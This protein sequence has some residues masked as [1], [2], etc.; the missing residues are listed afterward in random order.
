MTID[1]DKRQEHPKNAI[2][3]AKPRPVPPR[4]ELRPKP[5]SASAAKPGG[6]DPPR[7]PIPKQRPAP[8]LRPPVLKPV[9]ARPRPTP[10][11]APSKRV[12]EIAIVGI[13]G[14]YAKSPDVA[15]LW[16]NLVGG[17]NCVT[18]MPKERE[19]HLKPRCGDWGR[20]Q[21]GYIKDVDKFD[22]PFFNIP[23]WAATSIDPQERLLLEVAYEVLEDAGYA[24][25]K[26]TP[27]GRERNIGV[28]VGA[29]WSLYQILAA[30]EGLRGNQVVARSPFWSLSSRI[31]Y[32]FNCQGP[33]LTVDTACSSSLTAL[34]LACESIRRGECR[35]AIVGGVNLDL[36]PLKLMI[37]KS[38]NFIATDGKTRSFG[39]GGEGYV[40]AEGV[41]A[42]L[43]KP[44][45]EARRDGDHVQ[46]S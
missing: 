31:S 38:G 46:T 28:Y 2:Q 13:S 9:S 17:R 35:S 45:E 8:V 1:K 34:H 22:A 36:H 3:G 15:S 19:A 44:L 37:A 10:Q 29:V 32:H 20:I 12:Q 43:I 42:L 11:T 26:L 41:G 39:T 5:K 14:R 30:E 18:D 33:S 25:A 23:D 4:P 16:E 40:G 6:V 21:G 27:E 7:K 24:P